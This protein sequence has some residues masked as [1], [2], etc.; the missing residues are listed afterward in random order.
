MTDS[1]LSSQRLLIAT[2]GFVALIGWGAFAYSANSSATRDQ[3][4]LE[5]IAQITADRDGL[6]TEQQRLIAEGQ[7]LVAAQ[8]RMQGE[9]ALANV[10]LAETREEIALLEPQRKVAKKG[11]RGADKAARKRPP[12]AIARSELTKL[13]AASR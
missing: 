4:R 12:E 1:V 5:A 3:E 13:I 2:M 10:Q 8:Q 7:R 11:D 6:V 9:L